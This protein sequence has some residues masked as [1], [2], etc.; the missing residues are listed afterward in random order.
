MAKKYNPSGYQIIDIDASDKTS[1][2]AFDVVTEDEKLLVEILT[3]GVKKPLLMKVIDTAGDLWM[4]I[5]SFY[6]GV[7]TLSSGA[8]GSSTQLIIERS[9]SQ[10]KITLAEE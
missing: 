9:S 2:T 10:L 7:L 1:G 8:I 6:D 3:N 5:P 4:G